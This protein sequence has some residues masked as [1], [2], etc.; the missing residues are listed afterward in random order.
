[1]NIKVESTRVKK[2]L[3]Q[4]KHVTQLDCFSPWRQQLNMWLIPWRQHQK[5]LLKSEPFSSYCYSYSYKDV[6]NNS[7]CSYQKCKDVV[8]TAVLFVVSCKNK[9]TSVLSTCEWLSGIGSCTLSSVMNLFTSELN[10]KTT[11]RITA[12]Q[13]THYFYMFFWY[14][15][16]EVD[17]LLVFYLIIVTVW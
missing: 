13:A 10:V 15:L 1:M 5:D 17:S 4:T 11:I 7:G 14:L 16:V 12:D 9:I 8:T 3:R 2:D 6:E